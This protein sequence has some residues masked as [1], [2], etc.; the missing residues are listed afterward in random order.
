MSKYMQLIGSSGRI[1]NNE[2]SLQGNWAVYL[3]PVTSESKALAKGATA[4]FFRNSHEA[5]AAAFLESNDAV[6]R[7]ER[8]EVLADPEEGE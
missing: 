4:E 6:A 7:L 1:V 5:H 8:G 3:H 2:A